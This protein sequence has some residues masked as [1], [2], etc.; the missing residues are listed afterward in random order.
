MKI[1]Y[2]PE[3]DTLYIDLSPRTSSDSREVSE[4]V[5]LDYDDQGAVT[6][7]EFEHASTHLDLGEL[8]ISGLPGSPEIRESGGMA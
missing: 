2:F 5:V 7:I 8:I 1:T 3:T 4:D 6:G